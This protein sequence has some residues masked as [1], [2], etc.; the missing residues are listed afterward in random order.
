MMLAVQRVGRMG[1][2]LP[3]FE[4]PPVGPDDLG[5]G[6]IGGFDGIYGS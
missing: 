2:A 3:E 4:A 1:V 6:P 5:L